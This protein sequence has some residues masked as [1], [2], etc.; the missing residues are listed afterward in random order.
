M[1]H[2]S[3]DRIYLEAKEA[4]DGQWGI[5]AGGTFLV[6]IFSVLASSIP[7]IGDLISLIIAGPLALGYAMFIITLSKRDNPQIEQL[8]KGF[9]DFIRSLATYFLMVI[10]ILLWSLLL[11][12]PGIMKAYSYTMTF[13]ILAEDSEIQTMDAL[14]KSEEMMYGN[15][16]RLFGL[17]LK[18]LGWA[19]LALFTLGIGYF[20]LAPFASTAQYR[21]YQDLKGEEEEEFDSLSD[22][23]LEDY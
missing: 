4:M 14:K 13:Y 18:F 11:I 21:F 8:F 7:G 19:I 1:N 3:N 9:N 16:M 17:Q 10:F 6:T 5:A 20:W 2:K 12:V 23:L 22:H 15:R